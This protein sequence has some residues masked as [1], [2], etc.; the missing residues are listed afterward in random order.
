VP[1]MMKGQMTP[2]RN[3]LDDWNDHWLAVLARLKSGVSRQQAEAG[4]ASE[5]RALM[6]QQGGRLKHVDAKEREEDLKQKI[7]LSNGSQ[8]RTT[9]QRDSGSAIIAL[10]SMVVLVLLIACTNVANLLLAQGASRQREFTI[11]TA[12]G[13]TRFRIIRQ[14]IVESLLCAL[15]GGAFG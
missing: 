10:F 15:A 3:G 9:A 5:Y 8:G 12:M 11:R 14:L 1:L 13:A 6:E 4:I 7:L 2:L